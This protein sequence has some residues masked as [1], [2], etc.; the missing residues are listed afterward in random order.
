VREH[1]LEGAARRA[2]PAAA[3]G[4]VVARERRRR[5]VVGGEFPFVPA[6]EELVPGRVVFREEARLRALLVTHRFED[7]VDGGVE[8]G[9]HW[10]QRDRDAPR[11]QAPASG[12]AEVWRRRVARH[13][14]QTALPLV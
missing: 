8:G 3:T 12:C 6:A 2:P 14:Q 10:R 7:L 13:V 4:G 1:V 9:A 11:T 5:A